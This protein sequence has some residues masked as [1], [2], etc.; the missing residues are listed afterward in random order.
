MQLAY[1]SGVGRVE[2][3][4]RRTVAKCEYFSAG[5]SVKDRIA[6]V[7]STPLCFVHGADG[8]RGWWSAQNGTGFS[9]LARVWSLSRR[10]GTLVLGWHWLARSRDT[11][12]SPTVL[13]LP[14]RLINQVHHYATR[15]DE[16]GE[17][18]Y[19]EGAGSCDRADTVSGFTFTVVW[20]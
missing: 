3:K 13:P 16:L 7:G 15:K 2:V 14:R 8:V 12:R 10:V 5:G 1:V 18:G 11:S 9:S 4:L 20:S 17:G 19:A 6:K